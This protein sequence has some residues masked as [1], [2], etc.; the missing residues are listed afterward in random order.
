MESSG[1]TSIELAYR[2][3]T[4]NHGIWRDRS[5]WRRTREGERV[6]S[7]VGEALAH[8]AEPPRFPGW[9]CVFFER[10]H[11]AEPLDEDN[12]RSAFKLVGDALVHHGVLPDDSQDYLPWL[13]AENVKRPDPWC[14]VTIVPWTRELDRMRGSLLDYLRPR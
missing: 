11:R 4:M 8:L 12:L 5:H 1:R 6:R 10:G 3:P 14:R 13:V 9:V 2:P 7:L